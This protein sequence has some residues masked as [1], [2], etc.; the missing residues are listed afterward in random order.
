MFEIKR[1]VELFTTSK[2]ERRITFSK[3]QFK[4][5]FVFRRSFNLFLSFRAQSAEE[6][7]SAF[8]HNPSQRKSTEYFWK[9][10]FKKCGVTVQKYLSYI[11][12]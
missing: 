2:C 12:N 10:C 7:V 6:N 1:I 4:A 3:L 5:I 11:V 8:C 9:Y